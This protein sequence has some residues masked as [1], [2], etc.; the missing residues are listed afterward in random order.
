MQFERA[1]EFGMAT[2]IWDGKTPPIQAFW[3]PGANEI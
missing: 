2:Y 1:S 3:C